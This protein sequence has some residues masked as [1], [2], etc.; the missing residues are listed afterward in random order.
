MTEVSC[1]DCSHFNLRDAGQMARQG[2]GNCKHDAAYS[3]YS[4]S[5]CR[6][7]GKFNP[8]DV[9]V[10]DKRKAWLSRGAK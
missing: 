2:C 3:Y 10:I 1:V 8:A 4:A 9:K 7:C 6:D 5:K